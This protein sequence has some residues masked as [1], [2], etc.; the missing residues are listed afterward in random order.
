MVNYSDSKIY[1]LVNNVDEKIYVGSTCGTLRLRKSKH[2]QES[3]RSIE[4]MVYKH[5][6]EIG[7]ET[8]EIILIEAFECNNKD[9]LHKRE[10]YWI[11]ELKPELNK[12]LPASTIEEQNQR[13][14]KKWKDNNK[15]HLS[16]YNEEYR[17]KNIEDIKQRE[18]IKITCECGSTILKR[19]MKRHIKLKKH[20]DFIT[21]HQ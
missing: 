15:E 7:W 6:N 2:K 12:Q 18:G 17:K 14:N 4:R 20:I 5:L 10:R 13:K 16:T 11:D 8:V 9:E 19:S 21:T 3:T 1:K